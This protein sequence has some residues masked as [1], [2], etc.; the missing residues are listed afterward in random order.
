MW[1]GRG[2]R[3]EERDAAL[4]YAHVLAAKGSTVVKLVEGE[5]DD[6]EMFWMMLGEDDYAK[7]DYWQWRRTWSEPDPRIWRLDAQNRKSPVS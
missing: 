5:S 1:H 3:E 7:A 6:D 4:K 2:A